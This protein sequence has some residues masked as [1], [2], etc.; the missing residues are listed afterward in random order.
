MY[1]SSQTTNNSKNKSQ[2]KLENSLRQ[3]KK[4]KQNIPKL[5][6]KN[7]SSAKRVYNFKQINK[8]YINNLNLPNKELEKE[9]QT[10]PLVNRRKEWID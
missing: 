7:K 2:G 3:M 5:T 9:W 10:E 8:Q 6:G 1:K 4:K